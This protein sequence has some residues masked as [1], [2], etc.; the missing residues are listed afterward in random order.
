TSGCFAYVSYWLY[1]DGA[2][3][4][5]YVC[6][7]CLELFADEDWD[8]QERKPRRDRGTR[9]GRHSTSSSS[10]FDQPSSSHLNDND[11][12]GNDKGTSRLTTIP[13]RHSYNFCILTNT[14]LESQTSNPMPYFFNP[15]LPP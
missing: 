14:F 13:S 7:S 8:Q 1:E 3:L 10:A 9:R 11:D 4:M 15:S 5:R 2:Q 6:F 12:D